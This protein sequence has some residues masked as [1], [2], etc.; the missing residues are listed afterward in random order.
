[1][2]S[3]PHTYNLQPYKQIEISN[4]KNLNFFLDKHSTKEGTWGELTILEGSIEFVFLNG[5]ATVLSHHTLNLQSPSITIPPASWHKILKTSPTFKANLVFSCADHRYFEKKY[6]LAPM[7]SDLRHIYQ[8]YF[9]NHEKMSILDIGCGSGRNPLSLA[10]KGHDVIGVDKNE[11][12][13]NNIRHIAEQEQLTKIE[14]IVHDL[15]QP[16]KIHDKKFNLIYSTVTLQFLNPE[17]IKPLLRELQKLTPI[18]GMHFLVFP[19]E[20]EPY[21]YPAGFTYLAKEKE[22]YEFYQDCG[23]SVLEYNEKPGQLHR[24]DETG[25]PKQGV[26]ALL[27]AQRHI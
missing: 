1:M 11:S 18:G 24:L 2:N 4:E 8:T 19:V 10:V 9:G 16:L 25:K 15:N 13:I 23:W 22:L 21:T 3:L 17:R 14:T 5:D 27:L 12:G 7:H 20:K 26:F 6:Q